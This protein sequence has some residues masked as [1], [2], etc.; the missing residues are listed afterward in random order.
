MALPALVAGCA[1]PC[2]QPSCSLH[3]A[4]DCC[5]ISLRY[6][7]FARASC[8]LEHGLLAPGKRPGCTCRSGC[9][10]SPGLG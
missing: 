6:D 8:T 3:A 5:I 7:V 4:S 9:F 10:L 2:A 1:G